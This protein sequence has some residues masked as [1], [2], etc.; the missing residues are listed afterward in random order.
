MSAIVEAPNSREWDVADKVSITL[1]YKITG[2]ANDATAYALLASTAPSTYQGYPRARLRLSPNGPSAWSGEVNY[3]TYV[4]DTPPATNENEDSFAIA[5]ETRHITE[6]LEHLSDGVCSGEGAAVN[7]GGAINVT[8]EGVDGCDIEAMVH[9]FQRTRYMSDS[10]VAT[11]R[12]AWGNCC[13]KVNDGSFFG[14]AA[15]EVLFA[16][17]SGRRRGAADWELTFSFRVKRTETLPAEAGGATV[18]GWQYVWWTYRDGVNANRTV[19]VKDSY[20][21]ERVYATADFSTIGIGES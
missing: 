6:A 16:G 7:V 20:H 15:E 14:Y 8:S 9:T 12:S 3:A 11:Y 2:T 18:A 13:G 17:V 5:T 10:D 4:P 21:I 1:R 19:K